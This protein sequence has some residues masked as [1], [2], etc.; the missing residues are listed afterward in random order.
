VV[1]TGADVQSQT[2]NGSALTLG[3]VFFLLVTIPLARLVDWLISRQASKTERGGGGGGG[4]G[5]EL[6]PAPVPTG[7]AGA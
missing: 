1:Q 2:F 5:E 3:A 7:M 4:S 6:Q